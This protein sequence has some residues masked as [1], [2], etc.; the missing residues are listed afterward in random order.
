MKTEKTDMTQ[1]IFEQ[2]G[3]HWHEEPSAVELAQSLGKAVATRLADALRRAGVASLVVSGGSTPAPVFQY[4]AGV[5][6]DWSA[7]SVTLADE[8]WV[9]PGH[10]DSNE[11]L[12]RDTLLQDKASTAAFV[13][14]YREGL[15]DEQAL[16]QVAAD[17]QG[18]HQPFSVVMLGM[19]G[20]GHTAS[21]FPDAPSQELSAAMALDNNKTVAF[22]SPPSVTQR[23]ITLTRACLLNSEHRYLHITGT[24]KRSVLVDALTQCKGQSYQPGHAPVTGLLSEQPENTSI[25]WSP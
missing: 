25:Y 11:S 14:L 23:R 21:L 4:L 2:A 3:L 1:T 17:V 7:V 16:Q 19:G 12:V 5:D 6:I 9:P 22:L 15:S 20:D 18:M 24:G 13:A 8:R 10:P